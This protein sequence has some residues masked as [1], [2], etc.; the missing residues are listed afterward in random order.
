[1]VKK[2]TTNSKSHSTAGWALLNYF[3]NAS[4]F[5]FNTQ[6][7]VRSTLPSTIIETAPQESCSQLAE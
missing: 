6:D 2:N 7:E 3:R 5:S 4:G 1:M